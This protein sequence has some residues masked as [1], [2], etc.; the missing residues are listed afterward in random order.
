MAEQL[1][2][3]ASSYVESACKGRPTVGEANS[4]TAQFGRLIESSTAENLL[5]KSGLRN[6]TQSFDAGVVSA[7]MCYE[8]YVEKQC[9]SGYP[10]IRRSDRSPAE[11]STGHRLSPPIA[12][13]VVGVEDEVSSEILLQFL[14]R[15]FTPI[16][17]ESP[18]AEFGQR[19][20]GNNK[21]RVVQMRLV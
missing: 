9:G 7:V 6:Q 1:K 11:A 18:A 21:G 16:T 17:F 8:R 15:S 10:R 4:K 5:Y 14:P 2:I 3:V 19:H 12:H 20:E 13:L